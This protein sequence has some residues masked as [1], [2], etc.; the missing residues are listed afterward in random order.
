MQRCERRR[1][2]N[3]RQLKSGACSGSPKAPRINV[4]YRDGKDMVMT[5]SCFAGLRRHMI[6]ALKYHQPVRELKDMTP[7]ERQALEQR[8]GCKISG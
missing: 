6:V 4:K 3:F 2:R 5:W 1:L 8:Y 7:E